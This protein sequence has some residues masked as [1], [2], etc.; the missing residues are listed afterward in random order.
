MREVSVNEMNR[1]ARAKH[2]TMFFLFFFVFL[3]SCG[4]FI[5]TSGTVMFRRFI[6]YKIYFCYIVFIRCARETRCIRDSYAVCP[7]S[8]V[9][10]VSSGFLFAALFF[11]V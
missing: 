1:R 10:V 5:R 8:V 2:S 7:M 3:H 4:V 6:T 9:V 11:V